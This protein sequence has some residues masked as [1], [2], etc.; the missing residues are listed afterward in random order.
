MSNYKVENFPQQNDPASYLQR[1]IDSAANKGYKYVSHEYSSKLVPGS[2]G[3]FGFGA[4]PSATQ[5]VGFVVFQ[6]T[7]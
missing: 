2:A 1:L 5:H 4:K 7:E 3:C 6:K